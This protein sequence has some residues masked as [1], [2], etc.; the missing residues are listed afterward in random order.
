M[1]IRVPDFGDAGSVVRV[2]QEGFAISDA[3]DGK[4]TLRGVKNP[5]IHNFTDSTAVAD[6]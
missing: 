5:K 3:I 1:P 4:Q 2:C 6:M